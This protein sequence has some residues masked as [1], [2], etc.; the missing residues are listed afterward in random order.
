MAREED[1]TRTTNIPTSMDDSSRPAPIAPTQDSQL[2]NDKGTTSLGKVKRKPI[3]ARLEVWDHFTK[4]TNS[5]GEIKRRCNYCSK[6]FH[7]DLKKNGTTALRN[8][9]GNCKK[10][11]CAVKSRQMELHFQS[12]TTKGGREGGDNVASIVN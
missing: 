6:E 1:M 3:R 2:K 7:C 5:D 12:T 10:H 9:M 4:F 11:C 8:H